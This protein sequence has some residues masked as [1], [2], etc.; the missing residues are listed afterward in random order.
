MAGFQFGAPQPFKFNLGQDPTIGDIIY[1]T[2]GNFGLGWQQVVEGL[3]GQPSSN[4]YKW[5]QGWATTA[6]ADFGN[7]QA[8]DKNL[9]F[10]DWVNQYAPGL[11]TQFDMQ[12]AADRG[13]NTR[14]VGYPRF[15]G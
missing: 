6:R 3:G 4:F 7:A 2:P 14:L 5:L 13:V 11:N 15:L 10:Q 9:R 8:N 1:N 12:S